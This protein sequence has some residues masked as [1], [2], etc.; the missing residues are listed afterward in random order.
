MVGDIVLTLFPYTDLTNAKL[1]PAVVVAEV[2]MGD[3][4]LCEIIS[5]AHRRP[6]NIAVSQQD[7]QTGRL[8]RASWVRPDRIFTLS[9][10]LSNRR[11]GTLTPTKQAEISAALHDLL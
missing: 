4:I 2:T 10:S 8:R 3:W 9:R 5:S 7:M 11:I 1:R 6:E